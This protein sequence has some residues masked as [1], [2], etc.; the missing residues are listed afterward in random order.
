MRR[1]KVNSPSCLGPEPKVNGAADCS[2][3][4]SHWLSHTQCRRRA[5][6][7]ACQITLFFPVTVAAH[8]EIEARVEIVTKD[9]RQR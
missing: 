6:A 9:I 3:S 1:L 2:P 7:V 8:P 5:A 4:N